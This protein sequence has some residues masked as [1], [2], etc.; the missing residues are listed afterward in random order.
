MSRDVP[1]ATPVDFGRTAEDYGRHRAGLPRRFLEALAELIEPLAGR[2]VLDVGSGTGA[3]A[4]PLAAAGARVVAL[5]P[6]LSLLAEQRRLV[7][8]AGLAVRLVAGR[9]EAPGLK[10]R[11]FDLIVAVQ[12]WHWLDPAAAMAAL[13]RVLVPGGLLVLASHD[14]LPLP[15]NVVEATE[16][17]VRTHSPTWRLGGGD[18]LHPEYARDLRAGGFE[19]AADLVHDEPV[20][21]SHA[22]WRGRM[23]ASAGIGATL[24]PAGVEGFD[25]D[26][27]ALLAARFSAE[28]LAVPH[29]LHLVAGRRPAPRGAAGPSG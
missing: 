7:R 5:D 16:E 25:R 4:R 1:G 20:P 26:L 24:P 18:G 11:S 10:A 17:L 6:S 21:Y 13:A 3:A 15:G 9:A 12:C 28:P 19:L 29:R 14:W 27:A 23:R 22:A 8:A 2:A